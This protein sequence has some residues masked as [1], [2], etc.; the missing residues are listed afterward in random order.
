MFSTLLFYLLGFIG[1]LAVCLYILRRVE[2]L[3]ADMREDHGRILQ[4]IAELDRRIPALGNVKAQ[5]P[6]KGW[7]LERLDRAGMPEAFGASGGDAP[8]SQGGWTLGRT[9]AAGMTRT[10]GHDT[11][12]PGRLD[13]EP[14]SLEPDDEI[15]TR[16]QNRRR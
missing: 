14:L 2:K 15:P 12:P 16:P 6:G 10:V 7:S 8:P 11:F 13:F 3:S 4:M 5:P 9:G 1:L